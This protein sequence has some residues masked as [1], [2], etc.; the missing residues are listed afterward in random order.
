MSPM[1][2]Q[3]LEHLADLNSSHSALIL[4]TGEDVLSTVASLKNKSTP[5]SNGVDND[6]S[7][8]WARIATA[9][10]LLG[11]GYADEAHNLVG[12][13]S[14]PEELPYFHVRPGPPVSLPSDAQAAASLVHCLVHRREGPHVGEFGR[15]GFQ[16]ANFWVGAVLQP[17]GGES[18]PLAEIRHRMVRHL[19]C[20]E[21]LWERAILVADQVS[22]R[23]QD[24]DHDNLKGDKKCRTGGSLLLRKLLVK[25]FARVGCAHL[26]PKVATWRYQRGRRSLLENLSTV[27]APM[28]EKTKAQSIHVSIHKNDADDV[29]MFHVPD[30][31]ED[32]M[33]QLIN[34]LSDPATIV[35]W[36]A[37]KGIGLISE[38]LPALC[39]D[40]VLDAILE[41]CVTQ[42][43][44]DN[45]WHGAC[46]ALAELARRGL[47]LPT[48]LD[49]VVPIV[50]QAIQVNID[51]ILQ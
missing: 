31:V 1:R 21:L 38:R 15:T 5:L 16:N 37:A 6:S 22:P 14:F 13:L 32:A 26:P 9:L 18:L 33:D 23:S 34:A 43:D 28:S 25:L 40:D 41:L 2:Y 36:S 46:L 42:A 49:E 44:R 39:D 30:Q 47:L 50:V 8:A 12:P 19:G 4:P 48:R 24:D 7:E 51:C 27:N 11:H 17:G 20:V 29:E 45:A 35:R 10:I 3:T